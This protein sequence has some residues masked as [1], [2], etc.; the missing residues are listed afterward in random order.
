MAFGKKNFSIRI[1]VLGTLLVVALIGCSN[2]RPYYKSVFIQDN[3][4]KGRVTVEKIEKL[5]KYRLT[6]TD[7]ITG[8]SDRIYT[9]YRIFQM[10]TADVN[11]DGTTDILIGIVKPTPFDPVLKKR[12]FI[13]QIDRDYI[14]PLWLS[15]RLVYPL[16]EFTVIKK[17]GG[18]CCVHALEKI[19]DKLYCIDEYQWASFGMTFIRTCSD[20]LT[21]S[22]AKTLL[23]K[24]P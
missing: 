3:F 20:S 7:T 10:E 17:Q 5:N 14:R 13:F 21:H 15:S 2:D 6:I 11:N 8:E 19:S 4:F 24:Q 16:E 1:V 23:N 12:L 22:Q 9:P 18:E